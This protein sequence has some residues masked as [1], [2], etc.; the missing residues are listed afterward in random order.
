MPTTGFFGTVSDAE[1]A[2]W[3]SIGSPRGLVSSGW[4]ITPTA[5]ARE[6]SAAVGSGLMLGLRH[7]TTGATT[8]ANILNSSGSTRFDLIVWRADFTAKTVTLTALPGTPG[9]TVAPTADYTLL[10][11][12]SVYDLPICVTRTISGGGAY[13]ASDIFDIRPSVGVGAIH[14]PQLTHANRHNLVIGQEWVSDETL[15][16]YRVNAAGTGFDL[17]GYDEV[18]VHA[19]KTADQT[20]S[21]ST[22]K[23]NDTH[24]FASVRAASTYTFEALLLATHSGDAADIS[25]DVTHP[26][27]GTVVDWGGLGPN[28]AALAGAVSL[29]AGEWL[30]VQNQTATPTSAIPYACR[31]GGPVIIKLVGRIAVGSVA[32]T[33]RIRWSQLTATGT[34]TVL[35]G[36]Y[37]NVQRVA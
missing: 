26:G 28:N 24:M 13:S 27:S 34:T 22:V 3:A 6:I 10:A 20:V 31:T 30:A 11:S 36:S 19:P 12:G 1:F 7:D 17:I 33:L 35:A 23:V 18:P 21:A 15:A 4:G 32:G 2:R 37:L 9:L 25:I 8:V 16:R 5:N 14:V 29:G